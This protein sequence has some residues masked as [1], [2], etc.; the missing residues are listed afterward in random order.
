MISW[1]ASKVMWE[2]YVGFGSVWSPE[3]STVGWIS[4]EPPAGPLHMPS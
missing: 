1:A 2:K 4:G 3:T